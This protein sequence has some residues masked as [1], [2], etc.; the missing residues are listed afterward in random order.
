MPYDNN[1]RRPRQKLVFG[2]VQLYFGWLVS[3]FDEGI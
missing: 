2:I 1:G 3:Q